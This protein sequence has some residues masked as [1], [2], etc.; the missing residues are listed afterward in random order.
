MDAVVATWKR[1]ETAWRKSRLL[2]LC[3]S[4]HWLLAENTRLRLQREDFRRVFEVVIIAPSRW[5]G[6]TVRYLHWLSATHDAPVRIDLR[7][8]AA[9]AR[10]IRDGC[11]WTRRVA[12]NHNGRHNSMFATRFTALPLHVH[13][14]YPALSV[15]QNCMED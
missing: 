2:Q 3:Q 10:R 11:R 9:L 6:A 7:Q 8:H 14:S 5:L 12:V 1:R 13:F 15:C 4:A